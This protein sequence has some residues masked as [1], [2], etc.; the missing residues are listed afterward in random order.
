MHE[1]IQWIVVLLRLIGALT[2]TAT[3]YKL[4]SNWQRSL[5][6]VLAHEFAI[7][8]NELWV[9]VTYMF[10]T[11]T[12]VSHSCSYLLISICWNSWG[13]TVISHW[14]HHICPQSKWRWLVWR[15]DGQ[16]AR[17]VSK[18]PCGGSDRVTP[19][20]CVCYCAWA[21]SFVVGNFL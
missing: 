4:V 8:I 13:W 5:G 19:V 1:P 15:S 17:V 12:A 20:T 3:A 2:D 9:N 10:L 21:I 14:R 11:T 7:G 6:C 18:Q 16:E